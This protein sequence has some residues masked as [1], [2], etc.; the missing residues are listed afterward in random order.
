M[1]V[2]LLCS[3]NS[4]VAIQAC[5]FLGAAHHFQIPG[6]SSGL[7]EALTLQIC[8][9]DR[10][11]R[12]NLSAVYQDI[13]LVHPRNEKSSRER[14]LQSVASLIQL[15]DEAKSEFVLLIVDSWGTSNELDIAEQ[16]SEFSMLMASWR[17]N[18]AFDAELLQVIFILMNIMRSHVIQK[19]HPITF[20]YR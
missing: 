19:I 7:R 17:R 5:S 3:V 8:H 12:D 9:R 15:F 18:N 1:V 10:A 11:V 14:A 2:K 6:A 13:Y 16:Y 4:G 20:L